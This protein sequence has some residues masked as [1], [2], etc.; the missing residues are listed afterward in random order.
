V[1]ALWTVAAD[2]LVRASSARPEQLSTMLLTRAGTC[3]RGHSPPTALHLRALFAEDLAG[4]GAEANG[5]SSSGAH[6]EGGVQCSPAQLQL[7]VGY[8]SG[9][10]MAW[11]ERDLR[12]ALWLN[13]ATWDGAREIGAASQP[14]VVRL[15]AAPM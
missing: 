8:A 12:S 10:F 2:T 14:A 5:A 9:E 7:C 3:V 6:A 15:C 1:T 13:S 4:G 11:R